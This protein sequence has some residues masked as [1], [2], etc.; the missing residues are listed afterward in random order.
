MALA[1]LL[2]LPRNVLQI[3]ATGIQGLEE[4]VLSIDGRVIPPT[5][6]GAEFGVR[7]VSGGDRVEA[8]P[9]TLPCSL[10]S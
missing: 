5:A 6:T 8:G 3:R 2:T 7:V 1:N 4:A 9:L 10:C